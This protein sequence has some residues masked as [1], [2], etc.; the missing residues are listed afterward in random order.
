MRTIIELSNEIKDFFKNNIFLT[1]NE[2]D[3]I[4]YYIVEEFKKDF[5]EKVSKYYEIVNP[6][7]LYL[8]D[9]DDSL[10]QIDKL[11]IGQGLLNNPTINDIILTYRLLNVNDK[12]MPFTSGIFLQEFISIQLQR[13]MIQNVLEERHSIMPAI[14]V[15]STGEYIV[16]KSQTNILFYQRVRQLELDKIPD[17]VYK[18]LY[19]FT[20]YKIIDQILSEDFKYRAEKINNILDTIY[21]KFATDMSNNSLY[22]AQSITLGSISISL[23][24]KQELYANILSRLTEGLKMDPGFSKYIQNLKAEHFN[25]Y[26]RKKQLYYSGSFNL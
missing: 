7:K 21:Q 11:Y 18:L 2:I 12:S 17:S 6:Q 14:F 1:D 22:D 5:P 25:K 16:L 4:L 26:K 9:I 3:L 15:D 10:L 19:H 8:K 23:R 24:S 13:E 20:Y